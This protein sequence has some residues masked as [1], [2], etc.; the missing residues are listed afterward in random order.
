MPILS[1]NYHFEMEVKDV[2]KKNIFTSCFVL[3]LAAMLL[4]SHR[5]QGVFPAVCFII[6]TLHVMC[7]NSSLRALSHLDVLASVWQRIKMYVKRWCTLK[8]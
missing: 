2:K 4:W 3:V 5:W 7:N 6:P 8:Y 1:E